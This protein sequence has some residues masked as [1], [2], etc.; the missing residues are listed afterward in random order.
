MAMRFFFYKIGQ[1]RARK[2]EPRQPGRDTFK[3][4]TCAKKSCRHCGEILLNVGA[5]HPP[6]MS[7]QCASPCA[8]MCRTLRAFYAVSSTT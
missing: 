2:A 6:R 5:R 3:N 8:G 4:N 7:S 1:M